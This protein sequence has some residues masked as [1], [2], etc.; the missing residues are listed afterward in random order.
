VEA[1][2]RQRGLRID[3]VVGQSTW[4]T[5]VEAGL[6][7]GDRL[8]YRSQPMQ[9]GDDVAELQSRLCSLGFDTGRVD[10]I[11]GDSTSKALAEF[12]RNVQ[13]PVDAMAGPDTV[14]ELLR[15]SSRHQTLEL[16]SMVRERESR[17]SQPPTLRG[18]HI[19]VA[20]TGGLGSIA[21]SLN[22]RLASAGARVTIV[23]GLEESRQASEANQA[24]VDILLTL[25]VTTSLTG[26]VSAYYSSYSYE[27][28]VG[29]QLAEQIAPAVSEVL[30]GPSTVSGMSLPILRETKMPT[31]VIELGPADSVV[32]HT[33]ELA[34][35]LALAVARWAEA[36]ADPSAR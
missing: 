9:R 7:L 3:G 31:V 8:L 6:S 4:A 30:H 36:D 24:A 27:S 32:E 13:L 33:A 11:F 25:R 19:G 29:R 10:G 17:R 5:L 18:R 14:H 26:C 1:F 34:D 22:R 15:V 23:H 16:V 12:Q 20:E 2:Q 28:T 35:A 21:A